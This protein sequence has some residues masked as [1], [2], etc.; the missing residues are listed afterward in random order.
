VSPPARHSCALR[1]VRFVLYA[2][3]AVEVVYVVAGNIL[4]RAGAFQSVV[5][6][7]PQWMYLTLVNPWTSPAEVVVRKGGLTGSAHANIDADDRLTGTVRAAAHDV[8]VVVN[9]LVALAG[10]GTIAGRLRQ[11]T[12]GRGRGAIEDV[13]LALDPLTITT[14][15]ATSGKGSIAIGNGALLF[16]D[17]AAEGVRGTVALQFPSAKPIVEAVGAKTDA[18]PGLAKALVSNDNLRAW[19]WVSHEPRASDVQILTART[20]NARARGR[21][22]RDRGVERGAFLVDTKV[23]SVGV[24]IDRAGTHMKLLAGEGWFKETLA[25][26]DLLGK[27]GI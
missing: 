12:A 16:R 2:L 24:A 21:Y 6:S 8:D 23:G 19:V 26:L 15:G 1:I 20:D 22:K 3:V 17:L 11:E 7:D 25:R 13:E 9:D 27:G 4:L 18:I 14:R 5:N 10:D